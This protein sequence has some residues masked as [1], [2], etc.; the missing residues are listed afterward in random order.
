M[1]GVPKVVFRRRL[2]SIKGRLPSKVVFCPQAA[3]EVPLKWI[4][5]NKLGRLDNKLTGTDWELR[6]IVAVVGRVV[7]KNQNVE[8]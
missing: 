1:R 2:S 8:S 5:Q 4:K 7:Q 3:P 6:V